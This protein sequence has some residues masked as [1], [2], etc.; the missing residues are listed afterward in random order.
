MFE[1]ITIKKQE[2]R[3]MKRS[4]LNQLQKL[5][6]FVI[7]SNTI[8]SQNFFLKDFTPQINH[9]DKTEEEIE[10]EKLLQELWH[11]ADDFYKK[12]I[13]L[14][15]LYFSGVL[16]TSDQLHT[17]IMYELSKHML[18]S[19]QVFALYVP[20]LLY[21]P[22]ISWRIKTKRCA[23]VTSLLI[24]IT[25]WMQKM[26]RPTMLKHNVNIPYMPTM[27]PNYANYESPLQNS[28]ELTPRPR[29]KLS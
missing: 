27:Q 1:C 12:I 24:L 6:F 19:G 14:T 20:K 11:V 3:G 13:T 15:A 26:Y 16:A 28:I 5:L 17:E 23:Y 2:D 8:Q 9:H 21:N 4:A 25:I 10:D 22:H 18:Y 7:I 29:P